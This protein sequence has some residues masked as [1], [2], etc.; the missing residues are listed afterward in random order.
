[1][2][3]A[4]APLAHMCRLLTSGDQSGR[5]SAPI[6]RYTQTN[7]LIPSAEAGIAVTALKRKAQSKLKMFRV[8]LLDRAEEWCVKA[9]TVEQARNM[10]ARGKA[11]AASLGPCQY[12]STSCK[13]R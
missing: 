1:M 9:E 13:T 8:M 3:A 6:T 10:I 5:T 11:A 2:I 4:A 12:N 7:R